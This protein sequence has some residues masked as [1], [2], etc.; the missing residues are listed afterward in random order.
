[1]KPAVGCALLGAYRAAVS[2]KNSYVLLHTTVGCHWGTEFFHITSRQN[3][4]RQ[5]CS[6][7]Y[8]EDVIFGGARILSDTL[9]SIVQMA[10]PSVIFVISGCVSGII[11]EYFPAKTDLYVQ[12]TRVIFLDAVGFRDDMQQ[13]TVRM[14]L[15][16][17]ERVEKNLPTVAKTVNLVGMLSDDYRSDADLEVMQ[18]LLGDRVRIRAVIPYDSDQ[19]ITSAAGAA[20]NVVFK[21]YEAVGRQMEVQ[22]GIP[23][24]VVDYPYGIALTEKW[25]E[26]IGAALQISFAEVCRTGKQKAMDIFRRGYEYLRNIIDAP[27]AI[28]GDRAR[29]EALKYFLEHELGM[30]AEAFFDGLGADEGALEQVIAASNAI[31]IF[32]SSFQKG[33]AQ[34]L[35][36]SI[37]RFS[38]PI[39]DQ[40]C[41][42]DKSYVGFDGAITLFEDI[43]NAFFD[44]KRGREAPHQ[45]LLLQPEAR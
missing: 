24:V 5:S 29:A 27:V 45:L 21:G 43:I 28:I 38:Y 13:G 30:E 3:D 35:G 10:R 42:S 7:I 32:G 6:V 40:V 20:L 31:L 9:E 34:S 41:L 37:L 4:I 39:F 25:L 17:L 1:M 33:L 19:A 26:K 36:I 22:F 18:R 15:K 12:G 16:M 2:V 11:G 14:L 23:Y 44:L 8:N